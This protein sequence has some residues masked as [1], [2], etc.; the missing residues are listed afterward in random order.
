MDRKS[1]I[2]TYFMAWEDRDWDAARALLSENFTFTS[3][4]DDHIG[5]DTYKTRC[6]DSIR[7]LGKF[8]IHTIL[9]DGR[10][11]FVRYANVVNGQRVQNIEHFVIEDGL[12]QE[13]TVFFGR[14]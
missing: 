12:L 10:D 4:Y 8:N 1:T 2:R 13:V 7:S 9:A 3:Q 14:P 11:V 6:W 5:L